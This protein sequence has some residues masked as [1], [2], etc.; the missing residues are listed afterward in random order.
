MLAVKLRVNHRSDPT[1]PNREPTAV[2][3]PATAPASSA[4]TLVWRDKET[5]RKRREKR[6]RAE[7]RN[8]GRRLSKGAALR[9]L[10][11]EF[12]ALIPE[13]RATRQPSLRVPL[14]E[15]SKRTI[16]RDGL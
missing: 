13:D 11:E 10:A 8:G 3:F 12:R 6:W 15:L 4:P 16:R 2:P 14:V 7:K 1:P 5:R 9:A